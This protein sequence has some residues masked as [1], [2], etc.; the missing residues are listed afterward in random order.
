M[1]RTE[2]ESISP[3]NVI[4]MPSADSTAKL[5][6]ENVI[7][8]TPKSD[9]VI[10]NAAIMKKVSK[11][12]TDYDFEIYRKLEQR[13]G[14][15]QPRGGIVFGSNDPF[16]L[17]NTHPACQ[18]CLYGFE[19]DTY[20][21]GCVHNC[22]YCYSK[23]ELS[24]HGFWNR[25]FPMP[26]DITTVW[27]VFYT[28]FETDKPSKWRNILERRIPLRIG[29]GSDGFMHMDKKYRVTYELLKL[30]KFYNYPYII[31]TRSDLV[32]HDEYMSVLDPALA[33]IQ[34]SIPSTNDKLN[35][36]IEPGAPSA[37][38]RLKAIQKLSSNGFWTTVRINPLFPIHPDG[39][40]SDPNFSKE[41]RKIKF[42]Y[43]NF[44]MIQEISEHGGQ[45]L[46]AGFVRL[47][48][49][50]IKAIEKSTGI[51]LKPYFK[52]EV[53]RSVKHY[54]FS[55]PEITAYYEKIHAL[56]K[57]H[58][59]QF[60]TCYIGNEE[61]YF[62][63]HQNLWDNKK[64]CC[65]AQNRVKGF[66]KDSRQIKY[67][68]R[69]KLSSIKMPPNDEFGVKMPLGEIDNKTINKLVE[70]SSGLSYAVKKQSDLHSNK[71]PVSDITV[72][73]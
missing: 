20:G 43:F 12:K 13:F 57:V 67:D 33:S 66:T 68:E 21:R 28:V 63:M 10:A 42:D 49:I 69:T 31:V 22:Q 19:M 17:I 27:K 38:R 32:A 25:P 72:D 15:N 47:T 39:Y 55:A 48:G 41:K 71:R 46:L 3:D 1:D 64:D 58:G 5:N 52:K 53:K 34:L 14:I 29:S 6:G 35:K 61:S 2:T 65:N 9:K 7:I 44:D 26:R 8:P 4:K 70:R 62:W 60:T 50:S 59:V 56:C 11:Y 45:S 23:I 37:K 54:H 16:K 73:P 51:D 24:S 40:F 36:L 30:L 18:Q